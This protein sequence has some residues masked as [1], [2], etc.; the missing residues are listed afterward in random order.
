MLRCSS[1]KERV[2]PGGHELRVSP[3][4]KIALDSEKK[5]RGSFRRNNLKNKEEKR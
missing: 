3:E 1:L 2:L 4:R 5:S